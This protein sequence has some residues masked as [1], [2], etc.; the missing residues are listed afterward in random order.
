MIYPT[1]SATAAPPAGSGNIST[2]LDRKAP[3]VGSL[4]DS[5]RGQHFGAPAAVRAQV[6]PYPT[7]TDANFSEWSDMGMTPQHS[8]PPLGVIPHVW[9]TP[10]A[11]WAKTVDGG[12]ACP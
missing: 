8:K 5:P 12:L 10:A 4:R 7:L 11:I 3:F 1:R 2:G 6:R 9:L